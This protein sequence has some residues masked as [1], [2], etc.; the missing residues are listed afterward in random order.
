MAFGG[1]FVELIP[2]LA[3]AA[4]YTVALVA[5]VL[6]FARPMCIHASPAWLLLGGLAILAGIY[7]VFVAVLLTGTYV[8]GRSVDV[9][10]TGSFVL[11]YLAAVEERRLLAAEPE[12]PPSWLVSPMVFIWGLVLGSAVLGLSIYRELLANI[13]HLSL[14]IVLVLTI[15]LA[16]RSDLM[17]AKERT[18]RRETEDALRTRQEFLTLASHELRTP[19]TP[20]RLWVSALLRQLKHEEHVASRQATFERGLRAVDRSLSRLEKLAARLTDIAWIDRGIVPIH[21]RLVDLAALVI[22]VT[23][24]FRAVT[25]PDVELRSSI[26]DGAVAF[27]DPLRIEQVLTELLTN[28][29]KFGGGTPIDVRVSSDGRTTQLVVR[30][31]GLGIGE[32]ARN[33]IFGKFERNAPLGYG[34][35]G[36]GLFLARSIIEAHGGTIDV[37]SGAGAGTSFTIGLPALDV[38]STHP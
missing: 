37:T 30:D 23:E 13:P 5:G 10:W 6:V 7:F 14:L 3:R 22:E 19:L 36:L 4:G 33:R 27:C 21:P 25:D 15:L 31:H 8:V 12:A 18:L 2:P 38:K 20:M 11:I 17:L 9:L 35:L 16:I 34:G 1:S 28:A 24:S 29:I 26:Q 32:D